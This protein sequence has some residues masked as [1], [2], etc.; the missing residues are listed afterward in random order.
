M[1]NKPSEYNGVNCGQ[2]GIRLRGLKKWCD[3][4]QQNFPYWG[5]C[6]VFFNGLYYTPVGKRKRYRCN[7]CFH[8]PFRDAQRRREERRREE[9]RRQQRQREERRR[10]EQRRQQRQREER[11]REEQRRQ[12]RQREERQ[13]EEQRQRI[14][15]KKR[16]ERERIRREQME[17]RRR[18]EMERKRREEMERKRREEM[19]RKRREEME[20]KRRQEAER[21][22]REEMERKK[23]EEMEKRRQEEKER[24]RQEEMERKRQEM[25]QEKRST[26][27]Q[28]QQVR[29]EENRQASQ[30]EAAR[31]L[32]MSTQDMVGERTN[33]QHRQ[34]ITFRYKN[35]KKNKGS[36]R[37]DFEILPLKIGE[38]KFVSVPEEFSEVE[39]LSVE[40]LRIMQNSILEGTSANR[41]NRSDL[42]WFIKCATVFYLQTSTL[43][44]EDVAE[45][46][47]DFIS[48][49]VSSHESFDELYPLAHA[50]GNVCNQKQPDVEWKH[51]I[52]DS[53]TFIGLLLEDLLQSAPE[54]MICTTTMRYWIA[55]SIPLITDKKFGA[56]ILTEFNNLVNQHDRSKCLAEIHSLWNILHEICQDK[57]K[58]SE[59]KIE[60]QAIFLECLRIIRVFNSG[61]SELIRCGEQA[62]TAAGLLRN[63]NSLDEAK[64]ALLVSKAEIEELNRLDRVLASIELPHVQL[65]IIRQKVQNGIR[66]LKTHGYLNPTE[67]LEEKVVSSTENYLV[68][69]S[70]R[71]REVAGYWPTL[72]QI[73]AYCVLVTT[74][75]PLIG[76]GNEGKDCVIAMVAA[77]WA[78]QGKQVDIITTSDEEAQCRLEDWRPF[79]E[80]L[81]LHAS[82]NVTDDSD[83]QQLYTADILYGTAGSFAGDILKGSRYDRKFDLAIVDDIDSMLTNQNDEF[84][85]LNNLI[86]SSKLHYVETI[87]RQIW[88]TV[89]K[90]GHVTDQ[91]GQIHFHDE[92]K[93]LFAV[94]NKMMQGVE[95]YNRPQMLAVAVEHNMLTEEAISHWE[96]HENVNLDMH[97]VTDFFETLE[98]EFPVKF[99]VY[100]MQE[101]GTA[102]ARPF[103]ET[104]DEAVE[105]LSVLLLDSS[106]ACI[107]FDDTPLIEHTADVMRKALKDMKEVQALTT[108]QSDTT[109][110][111]SEISSTVQSTP[112]TGKEVQE[113]LHA[114][115]F[116]ES[117]IQSLVEIWVQNAFEAM[118]MKE[119][120]DYR[121]DQGKIL[122]S[123]TENVERTEDDAEM[124]QWTE[125]LQQFLEMKHGLDISDMLLLRNFLPYIFL[126][127]QYIDQGLVFGI[128]GTLD[129]NI[130]EE[131]MKRLHD[132]SFIV[133][134]NCQW[135]NPIE[136]PG[137][138]LEDDEKWTKYIC[139]HLENVVKSKQAALVLC[140]DSVATQA[141]KSKIDENKCLQMVTDYAET[142]S[143]DQMSAECQ[144]L[145]NGEVLV[146]TCTQDPSS[147]A[148]FT[149]KLTF[150]GNI[151]VIASFLPSYAIDVKRQL[152]RVAT[153]NDQSCSIQTLLNRNTLRPDIICLRNRS[154]DN[155]K[156]ETQSRSVDM[157]QN[158]ALQNIITEIGGVASLDSLL[159]SS[160]VDFFSEETFNAICGMILLH[161]SEEDELLWFIQ[162]V[163]VYFQQSFGQDNFTDVTHNFIAELLT[164]SG[165][166]EELHNLA[167]ALGNMCTQ[168]SLDLKETEQ[169]PT[170][171]DEFDLL[172]SLPALLLGELSKEPKGVLFTTALRHMIDIGIPIT[173]NGGHVEDVLLEFRYF[174]DRNICEWNFLDIYH[175]WNIFIDRIQEQELLLECLKVIRHFKISSQETIEHHAD[176]PAIIDVLRTWKD[177]ANAK[178]AML[179]LADNEENKTLETILS[180]LDLPNKHL[181]VIRTTVK[182]AV[183]ELKTYGYPA[184]LLLNTSDD[185]EERIKTLRGQQQ[186][187]IKDSLVLA[188][189]LVRKTMGYWPRLTQM[190]TY[191]ILTINSGYLLEVCTGEG[192]SCVIAMV[193]ATFAL[194]GKHVDIITSSPVLAKRDAD[195]W[196]PFYSE[197]T[198]E[199]ASNVE[200]ME[201]SDRRIAYNSN[202]LYGTVGSFAG[203]ILQS[204]FA[205]KNVRNER[206]F[207][208]VIVDEVDSMLIDQGVQFTYL[209]HSIASTGMRHLEP[210][211]ARI[212]A[213]VSRFA[214]VANEDGNVYFRREPQP[215][216]MPVDELLRG[217]NGYESTKQLLA[218]AQELGIITEDAVTNWDG[219]KNSEIKQTLEKVTN[220]DMHLFFKTLEKIVPVKFQVYTIEK[221]RM[222]SLDADIAENDDEDE[223]IPVLLYGSGLACLL[224][225]DEKTLS[226]NI[227]NSVKNTV[228]QKGHQPKEDQL[229]VPD[230]LRSFAHSRAEKWVKN[231]FLAT[232][233]KPNRE[234]IVSDGKV[235]PVDLKSTGVVEL[236]KK[237]GDGLQQFLE[238]K[239]RIT[240][241]PLSLVTNFLSNICLFRQYGPNSILGLSGT[242]GSKVD[243]EFMNDIFGVQFLTIPT[244]KR[245]KIIEMPGKILEDESK[246]KQTICKC[247]QEEFQNGRAVL[248]VCEDIITTGTL[249]SE[250]NEALKPEKLS[251]YAR[252]DNPDEMNYIKEK[253]GPGEVIIATNLAGR[254]TDVKVTDDVRRAGGLA[255]VITFLP[256][257]QRVEKQAFGRTGR[258]GQPG[259]CQ[260]ILNRGDLRPSLRQC[261][262]VSDG[263]RLRDEFEEAAVNSMKD[264]EV[265][266]VM[267][268][269]ELFTEY[270]KMLPQFTSNEP[271]QM[272]EKEYM[273]IQD[274][275]SR[276]EV[277]HE[278]WAIWLQ[279][280]DDNLKESANRD[281]LINE[282]RCET[283]KNI[284]LVSGLGSPSNNFYHLNKFG[285]HRMGLNMNPEAIEI[286]NQS[287]SLEPNWCAVAK[288]N[289]ARCKID[290]SDKNYLNEAIH[291]LQ[292]VMETIRRYREEAV[293]TKILLFQSLKDD[294]E[295]GNTFEISMEARCQI[296]QMWESNTSEALG[297]LQE[298]KEKGRDA[299][300]EVLPLFSIIKDP[301]DETEEVLHECW[302]LGLLNLFAVK[303]KPRFCW[304]A[305]IVFCLGLFQLAAG[306][307]LTL[308]SCGTLFSVGMGLISE[309]ISDCID[310][311]IGMITGTFDW[312]SWGI[313]KAISIA[314]SV[315]SAGIGKLVAKG[316]QLK[317]GFKTLI[318]DI[319]GPAQ[320]LKGLAK[321]A[322]EA[323]EQ[324]VT[325]L[326]KEAKATKSIIKSEMKGGLSLAVKDR[327]IDVGKVVAKEAIQQGVIQ[328]VEMGENKL[329][330]ELMA[331]VEKEVKDSVYERIM[332]ELQPGHDLHDKVRELFSLDI[333]ESGY[334]EYRN[335]DEV[336]DVLSSIASETVEPSLRNLEWKNRV[337]NS[338]QGLMNELQ[339][340][341]ALK[342][343]YGTIFRVIEGINLGATLADTIQVVAEL[344][345]SFIEGV[346]QEIQQRIRE[347]KERIE[348]ETKPE[349]TEPSE[350]FFDQV[351]GILAGIL[352]QAMITIMHQ[353]AAN[354][355][356][357]FAKRKVN[358]FIG[359]VID[360]EL[361]SLS[362]T[363]QRLQDACDVQKISYYEATDAKVTN[364]LLRT[365]DNYANKIIHAKEE[366]GLMDARVVS[367]KFT[368]KIEIYTGGGDKE[369]TL[370]LKQLVCSPDVS[371]DSPTIKLRLTPGKDGSPGHYEPIIDG[372]VFRID[373]VDNS[374]FF[375]SVSVSLGR[376]GTSEDAQVLRH[377]IAK[378][379]Q[380]NPREYG[381]HVQRYD[382][383]RTSRD[384]G[385]W[386]LAVGGN[387]DRIGRDRVKPTQEVGSLTDD[388]QR[389]LREL[390][391]QINTYKKL[392]GHAGELGSVINQDHMPAFDC[393]RQALKQDKNCELAKC[394]AGEMTTFESGRGPQMVAATVLHEHHKLFLSTG[395]TKVAKGYRK[396]VTDAISKGDV[397]LTL[398]LTYIGSQNTIN[399][400]YIAKLQN[401]KDLKAYEKTWQDN[402]DTKKP[403]APGGKQ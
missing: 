162:Y 5:K 91:N 263:K 332:K 21:K 250:I 84:A 36:H 369:D 401:R 215:F 85:H 371:D 297:K 214:P 298:I 287:I 246:W 129:S 293:T 228:P 286:Y 87:L 337:T 254:G 23:R 345:T 161:P 169:E 182:E 63:T 334:G 375:Q 238:M 152:C 224:E 257:N 292:S 79:Y 305:F 360:S 230:F 372:K 380:D 280:H 212:W 175:L 120:Q 237:W 272:S 48:V 253:L 82:Q 207:D 119:N 142:A 236:N 324:G 309:G 388:Q 361:T 275:K 338:L 54:S 325:T 73:V 273:E 124:D 147:F 220:N 313:S 306:A 208:L 339:Q 34:K 394:L 348:K 218:I 195:D 148:D 155:Y 71:V 38:A 358:V 159:G 211:L 274:N 96:S 323:V 320:G 285:G 379:I 28:E 174:M 387:P 330:T 335:H 115:D 178:D 77:T 1:G 223:E 219:M 76:V 366:G 139:K 351:S 110:N 183:E 167:K 95:G 140:E 350:E 154:M 365:V 97:Q 98:T 364:T 172:R 210:V 383:I 49:L 81:E 145:E 193:A 104:D 141:L 44:C 201:E 27:E 158:L 233:M 217:T 31:N 3:L 353:R 106:L 227:V 384:T 381:G 156:N 265:R 103:V 66:E 281:F 249:Q 199:V 385:N 316:K 204:N 6:H 319:K 181:D 125:G 72:E 8:K 134:P 92:P 271:I 157:Q 149:D 205:K 276:L 244:H 288:Y 114:P 386:L 357:S 16:E 19:E 18:E 355:M 40:G 14:E 403:A 346:S 336:I 333:E 88:S 296:L 69:T 300:V 57:G 90:Y 264:D 50:L 278:A 302:Q 109:G 198:L 122:Q 397:E 258:K 245:Q 267:L 128:S 202:I 41:T 99:H 60:E 261:E 111:S 52:S 231:A 260:I 248:V 105:K 314:I 153:E 270:C 22:R 367:K 143:A 269:E 311:T 127:Q 283:A 68:L 395:N 136:L 86:G 11:R 9:Q 46:I 89:K 393:V 107:C 356:S 197:F 196:K 126:L 391:G 51:N 399:Q 160:E 80:L 7:N 180:E 222:V 344:S 173:A 185:V 112:P 117:F 78:S 341:E 93:P 328:V 363:K 279:E 329:L 17:K 55:M 33:H 64:A 184:Q 26:L 312:A 37:L 189:L 32:Y 146:A 402:R 30:G 94:V 235:L 144:I 331:L 191:C 163:V 282:L 56:D 200:S 131:L 349:Q 321:E 398:K 362:K 123:D 179:E 242:L 13:R 186:I 62:V 70:R 216:F 234:Y 166:K 243:K 352:A 301:D 209:S 113:H 133:I 291:D 75:G 194:Q 203:D 370:K 239:H 359:S 354:H 170:D 151:A 121:I 213:I 294:A 176:K 100:T 65:E 374:C 326:V 59:P 12:Q 255:V 135:H 165:D 15:R 29:R 299:I 400:T 4:R 277:L 318:K 295:G 327:M 25:E 43:S 389:K 390:Y 221:D 118:K 39:L 150:S 206:R 247:L 373:N 137:K 392:R 377:E 262:S 368:C 347:T 259:S 232:T 251:V 58:Q 132:G 342:T 24:K 47:Y 130:D 67:A 252:S 190:T 376:G 20:R 310:G 289:R 229:N 101:N 284:L 290:Q 45:E 396:L 226:H 116:F 171:D 343:K 188:S 138:I 307:L 241:S 382:L 177:L 240:V 83:R 322:G 61:P 266:E 225:E 340:N 42:V 108:S 268:K 164:C 378:T 308:V 187:P 10:E 315:V 168:R 102:F 256:T 53:C 304:D 2:C 35:D 303:E 317:N 192:K 74:E